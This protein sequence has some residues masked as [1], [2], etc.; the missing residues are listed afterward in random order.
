MGDDGPDGYRYKPDGL[1]KQSFSITT[2]SG[3]HLDTHPP[4]CLQVRNSQVA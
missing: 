4:T 1:M 2:Q 3:Q